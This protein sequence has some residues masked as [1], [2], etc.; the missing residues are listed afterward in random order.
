M[1][2]HDEHGQVDMTKVQALLDDLLD[3][4]AAVAAGMGPGA[5]EPGLRA[6]VRELIDECMAGPKDMPCPHADVTHST[7]W[8]GCTCPGEGIILGKGVISGR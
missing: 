7:E 8:C 2:I 4:L 1:D 3:K 5:A 6:Q